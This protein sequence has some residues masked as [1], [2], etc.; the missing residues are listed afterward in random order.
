MQGVTIVC[1]LLCDEVF[2]GGLPF[3]GLLHI[4]L[5]ILLVKGL[6]SVCFLCSLCSLR[7]R[8]HQGRVRL[9]GV[10]DLGRLCGIVLWLPGLLVC[11]GFRLSFLDVV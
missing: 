6:V 1:W 5:R 4:Q 11:G 3:G 7:L 2:V 9:I 10:I 8:H